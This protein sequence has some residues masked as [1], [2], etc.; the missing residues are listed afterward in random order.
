MISRWTQLIPILAL[1]LALG[2]PGLAPAATIDWSASGFHSQSWARA[3]N[4]E[5]EIADSGT[6]IDQNSTS[7]ATA[8]TAEVTNVSVWAE[9]Q[10]QHDSYGD[11]HRSVEVY[12]TVA[13]SS[14]YSE[15]RIQ[16]YGNANTVTPAVTNGIFFI[17]NPSPGENVGDPVMLSWDWYCQ[18]GTGEGGTASLTGGYFADMTVTLNDYPAPSGPDPAKTIWTYAGL[19]LG[20]N[21]YFE[22]ERYGEEHLAHIG[23]IIGVHLGAGASIDFTGEGESN[24]FSGQ[25]LDLYV[26]TL[27]VPIPG[28]VWLLGSGLVGLVG[29]RRQLKR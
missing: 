19:V 3:E 16:A 10:G 20:E 7:A 22:D 17:I 23:D 26:E 14:L 5:P 18:V 4:P 28:A 13:G 2:W 29:L 8:P 6:H 27:P 15:G 24:A 25:H 1:A 12:A 21:D 11:N 9:N